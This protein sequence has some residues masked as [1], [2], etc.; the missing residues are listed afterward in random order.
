MKKRLICVVAILFV[1]HVAALAQEGR[2]FELSPGY[3]HVSGNQGLDGLDAGAAYWFTSRVAMAFDYDATWDS[4]TL[5][6]FAT[7]SVGLTSV[8]SHLSDWLIGPRIG[9]PGLLHIEKFKG[10]AVLPYL[11]VQMGGSHLSST[12]KQENLGS[13]SSSDT[14]FTWMIGGGTD[15]KLSE[16][17]KWFARVKVDFLRTHFVSQGQSRVRIGLGIA[18]TFRSRP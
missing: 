14:G 8:H 11:E 16:N 9:M 5:G 17:A 12:L 7:S 18:H 10:H 15:I 13:T 1:L 2:T 3:V 4:S 6:A